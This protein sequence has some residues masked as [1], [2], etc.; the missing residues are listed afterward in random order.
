MWS[1]PILYTAGCNAYRVWCEWMDSNHRAV[2]GRFTVSCIRPLCHTHIWWVLL[3][4]SS[5][6]VRLLDVASRACRSRTSCLFTFVHTHNSGGASRTRTLLSRINSPPL[7]HLAKAPEYLA[8]PPGL[9]PGLYGF[10]DRP[11]SR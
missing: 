9:E 7:H 3:S 4:S 1:H 10:G 11:H 2:T 5:D 8:C 6:S